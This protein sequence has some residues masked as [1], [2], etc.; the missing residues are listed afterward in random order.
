MTRK[1]GNKWK[2]ECCGRCE[3]S[4][5]GYS[6]KLDAN[7]VEY[8]VCQ[9][10]NKRMNVSGTGSEANSFA[11]PT[12]WGL[13]YRSRPDFDLWEMNAMFIVQTNLIPDSQ[14]KSLNK[15]FVELD[16]TPIEVEVIPFSEVPFDVEPYKNNHYFFIGTA[17]VVERLA[18]CAPELVPFYKPSNYDFPLWKE[19]LGY[20]WVNHDFS[21]T[22]IR[23]LYGRPGFIKPYI[24]LKRWPALVSPTGDLSYD[25]LIEWCNDNQVSLDTECLY[26]TYMKPH[27]EY[28]VVIVNKEVVSVSL[29]PTWRA[30]TVTRRVD[31]SRPYDGQVTRRMEP[32]LF[33]FVEKVINTWMPDPTV[34]LDVGYFREGE[35]NNDFRV[36]E[37]NPIHAAGFVGNATEIIKA[38]MGYI[39]VLGS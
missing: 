12:K 35:I 23:Y 6:G 8:V 17:N 22:S 13:E 30:N 36:I 19:Q 32:G 20:L 11:F 28:R 26:A 33:E 29:Y 39:K 38:I 9:Y 4:H 21:R 16:V 3:K 10:T 2:T 34:V 15:A 27:S 25:D 14:R 7:D 37:F 1:T 24:G 18:E 31:S 5:S